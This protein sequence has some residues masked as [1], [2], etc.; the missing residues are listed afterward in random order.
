VAKKQNANRDGIATA[1][2][3]NDQRVRGDAVVAEEAR[4]TENL[5][6]ITGNVT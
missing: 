3:V 4:S 5:C 2:K 1:R 6:E